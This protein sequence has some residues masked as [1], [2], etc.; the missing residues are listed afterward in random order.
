MANHD[1]GPSGQ[2]Q[3]ELKKQDAIMKEM[4]PF[5]IMA[6]FPIILTIL[7]AYCFGPSV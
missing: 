7:I 2:E 6:A 3:A 4:M 1:H 5:F